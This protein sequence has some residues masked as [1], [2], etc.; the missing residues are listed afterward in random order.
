MPIRE[1]ET[2]LDEVS[3][4]LR[5]ANETG[6]EIADDRES[7]KSALEGFS[8]AEAKDEEALAEARETAHEEAQEDFEDRV[9]EPL[10]EAAA[11][12]QEIQATAQAEASETQEGVSRLDQAGDAAD[13][14]AST[15]PG[16]P[17]I[18]APRPSRRRPPGRVRRS[19]SWR[20]CARMRPAAS[21]RRSARRP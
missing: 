1:M 6:A 15:R 4:Q 2:G 21:R 19:T 10:D 3:E 5:E 17:P 18:T 14:G 16:T 7:Q 8:F 13:Y 20:T 12:S 11:E 9:R